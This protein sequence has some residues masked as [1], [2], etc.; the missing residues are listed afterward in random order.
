MSTDGN[1]GSSRRKTVFR[2]TWRRGALLAAMLGTAIALVIVPT[3]ALAVHDAGCASSTNFGCL[4]ELDGNV[5]NDLQSAGNNGGYDWGT[6]PGGTGVFDSSGHVT[7]GIKA[8]P[9]FLTA[10]F[11]ADY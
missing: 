7:T 4:F 2:F 9:A 1:S 10:D 11:N 8:D 6:G 3:S 5:Q